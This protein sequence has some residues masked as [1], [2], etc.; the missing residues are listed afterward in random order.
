M[1]SQSSLEKGNEELLNKKDFNT[2]QNSGIAGDI[3]TDIKTL[4]PD[5]EARKH[6][7]YKGET[8]L[9]N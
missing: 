4:R 2:K 9:D 6:R 7:A 1:V 5:T 3:E 8:K